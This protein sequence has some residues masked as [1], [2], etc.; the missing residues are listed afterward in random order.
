MNSVAILKVLVAP[1]EGN[2]TKEH[3]IFT[4]LFNEARD[5]LFIPENT[6]KPFYF[7]VRAQQPPATAGVNALIK[8]LKADNATKI[9][10]CALFVTYYDFNGQE[11]SVTLT[12]FDASDKKFQTDLDHQED[13]AR[14]DLAAAECIGKLPD[15]NGSGFA[16]G[17]SR[18]AKSPPMPPTTHSPSPQPSVSY[19]KTGQNPACTVPR[20]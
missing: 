8:E 13:L 4:S 7:S 11:Q 20:R 3:L 19:P 15:G 18:A 2:Q 12:L 10:R 5:E 1:H 9:Q 16:L 17:L 6:S 14:R